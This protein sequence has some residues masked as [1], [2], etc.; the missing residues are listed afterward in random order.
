MNEQLAERLV[1]RLVELRRNAEVDSEQYA[2]ASKLYRWLQ[3]PAAVLLLQKHISLTRA[4]WKHVVFEIVASDG[5]SELF[6]I[7]G[8]RV[9]LRESVT[10][11][12]LEVL[13]RAVWRVSGVPRVMG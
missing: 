9:V 1:E 13:V 8:D 2:A 12:D 4:P 3:N 5:F 11:Q 6:E 7:E 10:R